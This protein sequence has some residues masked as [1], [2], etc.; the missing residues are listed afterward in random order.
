MKAS[1]RQLQGVAVGNGTGK[2]EKDVS[3]CHVVVSVRCL[4][5]FGGCRSASLL[6][7]V[8]VAV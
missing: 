3:A 1:W 7:G 2:W 5:K 6:S 8:A 4:S